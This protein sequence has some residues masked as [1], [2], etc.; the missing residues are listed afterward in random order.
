MNN[1]ADDQTHP[2]INV[3]EFIGKAVGR[4]TPLKPLSV[5]ETGRSFYRSA[6]FRVC[7]PGVYRFESFEEADK[8]ML[9]MAIKRAHQAEKS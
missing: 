7:D 2:V 4:R 1:A 9:E 5:Q 6:G 8:W 3:E